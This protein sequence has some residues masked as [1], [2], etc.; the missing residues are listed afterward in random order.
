MSKEQIKVIYNS[1]GLA[2]F[3]GSHIEINPGLKKDKLLRDYVIKHELGHSTNFDFNHELGDGMRLFL[4]PKIMFKL[5]GF[6]IKNPSTLKDLLPLQLRDKKLVYDINL[7]IFYA[8][9]IGAI[10]L[11]F[12]I[13]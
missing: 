9:I 3:Y 13:F 11:A 7:C 10:A 4:R 5:L 6:Y 12:K 2:N 8:L 1:N